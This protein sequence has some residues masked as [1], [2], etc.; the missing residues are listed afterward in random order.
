LARAAFLAGSW[1]AMLIIDDDL[2]MP[3]NTYERLKAM[4]KP[5]AMALTV[6]RQDPHHWSAHLESETDGY[7]SISRF[8]ELAH[9]AWGQQIQVVGCG[10]NPTLIKREVIDQIP[11]EQRGQHG[12]DRY[13][14]YDCVNKGIEMWCDCS[15]IVGHHNRRTI[16]YPSI[17][18]YHFRGENI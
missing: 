9:A 5:V 16:W 4:D 14:A 17:D 2:V 6:Q 15:L 12:T 8:P 11:F 7:R 13:F 18:P 1:D 3:R 10:H